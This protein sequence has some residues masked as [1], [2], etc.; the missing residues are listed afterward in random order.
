MSLYNAI[1]GYG[2]VAEYQISGTPFVSTSGITS[3]GVYNKIEFP[4]ITQWII[5]KT[6]TSAGTISMS[7]D[8]LGAQSGR[9]IVIFTNSLESKQ[10]GPF[11]FRVKD[12]YIG[13]DTS[14]TIIAGLTSIPRDRAP[15]LISNLSSSLTGSAAPEYTNFFAYSG[16]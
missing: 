13:G 15:T 9:E 4:Y 16:I 10:L 5:L 2:N 7:F 6:G 3:V 8:K 12:I 14:T 1:S 11:H